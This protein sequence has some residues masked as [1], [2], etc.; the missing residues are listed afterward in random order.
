MTQH[1]SPRFLPGHLAAQS[2]KTNHPDK[3]I[4]WPNLFYSGQQPHLRYITHS[5]RGRLSG[6]LG[7]YHDLSILKSWY[8]KRLGEMPF[9][10]PDAEDMHRISLE[11]LLWREAECD[12]G[13][14]DTIAV[15]FRARPLFFSF[16]HPTRWLLI[17]LVKGL[18]ELAGLGKID[19]DPEAFPEFL[20]KV[21]PPSTWFETAG[22]SCKGRHVEISDHVHC[23]PGPGRAYSAAELRDVSFSCYDHYRSEL[24]DPANLRLT[25]N[26]ALA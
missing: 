8:L 23:R 16:N 17:E 11:T 1:T 5:V 25:P 24:A 21:I 18:T 10:L 20:D 9:E 14:T 4:V 19:P 15:N 22:W 26:Y 12:I 6:P 2:I 7:V 13:L 3:T